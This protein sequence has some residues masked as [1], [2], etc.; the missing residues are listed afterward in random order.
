M[1]AAKRKVKNI[2]FSFFILVT[3]VHTVIYNTALST[4][5]GGTA[6]VTSSPPFE[7]GYEA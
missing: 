2:L 5:A 6:T 1:Q 4:T 7:T 3:Q